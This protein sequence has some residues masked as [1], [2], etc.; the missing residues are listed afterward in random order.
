MFTFERKSHFTHT[1]SYCSLL[2]HEHERSILSAHFAL[3]KH[4]LCRNAERKPDIYLLVTVDL[5]QVTEKKNAGNVNNPFPFSSLK[6]L[7]IAS[8]VL[9]TGWKISFKK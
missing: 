3:E 6:R 9:Q 8:Y 5:S 7:L 2:T 1:F 4:E